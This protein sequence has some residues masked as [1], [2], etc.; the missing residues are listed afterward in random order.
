MER[1]NKS[2]FSNG[3]ENKQENTQTDVQNELFSLDTFETVH[4]QK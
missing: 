3:K 4:K 2:H 1:A